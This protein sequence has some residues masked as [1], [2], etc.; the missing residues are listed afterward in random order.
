MFADRQTS[1]LEFNSCVMT[2]ADV[3]AFAQLLDDPEKIGKVPRSLSQ[4]SFIRADDVH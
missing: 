2:P 1:K 3:N 4:F